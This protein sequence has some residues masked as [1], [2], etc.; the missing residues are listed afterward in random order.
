VPSVELAFDCQIWRGEVA[1][2]VN[3]SPWI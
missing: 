3:I 1:K 2:P